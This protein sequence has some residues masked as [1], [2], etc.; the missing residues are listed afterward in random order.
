MLMKRFVDS[1]RTADIDFEAEIC[2]V[3]EILRRVRARARGL[4]QAGAA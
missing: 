1:D 3:R 2:G 4:L